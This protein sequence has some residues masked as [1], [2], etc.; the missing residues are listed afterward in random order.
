MK[1]TLL[2]ILSLNI[3]SVKCQNSEL[4]ELINQI[5]DDI[6]LERNNYFVLDKSIKYSIGDFE[7]QNYQKR[8]LKNADPNFPI[9]LITNPP[10]ELNQ[11]DWTNLQLPKTEFKSEMELSNPN[12]LDKH[13]VYYAF[14]TP[15]FSKNK[16]YCI[17]IVSTNYNS[18]SEYKNYVLKKTNKKWKEI[19]NFVSKQTQRTVYH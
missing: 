3:L 8:D 16:K 5:Y 9:D 18:G 19:F 14:S 10:T 11:T 17:I 4:N 2:L 6:L 13:K 7:L 15:I 12:F 1:L